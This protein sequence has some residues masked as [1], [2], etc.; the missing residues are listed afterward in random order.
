MH[1]NFVT[2]MSLTFWR[3]FPLMAPVWLVT[4]LLFSGP[5][6]S[7]TQVQYDQFGHAYTQDAYG[8]LHRVQAL[9]QVS[10]AP[11]GPRRAALPTPEI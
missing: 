2:S 7:T 3:I 10:V 6:R 5:R 11:R 9:D 8:T 1:D 4:F